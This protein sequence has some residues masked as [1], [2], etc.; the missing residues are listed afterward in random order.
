MPFYQ[1][2]LQGLGLTW[3][4]LTSPNSLKV[5]HCTECWRLSF[6]HMIHWLT[7]KIHVPHVADISL[8]LMSPMQQ[9]SLFIASKYVSAIFRNSYHLISK[10][11]FEKSMETSWLYKPFSSLVIKKKSNIMFL[12]LTVLEPTR[13]MILRN[14]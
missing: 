10:I 13:T 11:S 4:S 1:C 7:F 12:V 9:V 6:Q 2:F 3:L 14:F 8:F 5:S